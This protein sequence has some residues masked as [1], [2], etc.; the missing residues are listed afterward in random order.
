[1][2]VFTRRLDQTIVS[3]GSHTAAD[4]MTFESS[5]VPLAIK[6]L[7]TAFRKAVLDQINPKAFAAT[8][9]AAGKSICGASSSSGLKSSNTQNQIT[10][11]IACQ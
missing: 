9:A 3:S 2:P 5:V 4:A 6:S 10:E 1:M 7:P 8:P 11:G